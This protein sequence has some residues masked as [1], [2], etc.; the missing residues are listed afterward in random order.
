MFQSNILTIDISVNFV[1]LL[2][3][4]YGSQRRSSK[5]KSF[6]DIWKESKHNVVRDILQR[7]VGREYQMKDDKQYLSNLTKFLE[8]SAVLKYAQKMDLTHRR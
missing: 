8:D 3:M 5:D 7:L 4:L 2:P 6:K 1:F